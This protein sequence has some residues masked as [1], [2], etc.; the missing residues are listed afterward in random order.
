M[1]RRVFLTGLGGVV[2]GTS[3]LL[4][5]SAATPPLRIRKSVAELP[6]DHPDLAAL[7]KAIPLMRRSGAW[8][9]Q[10]AIHA[11]IGQRHHSSWRFLPWHRI[12]LVWFE[13][14][15]ARLSGYK[16]FAL[17]YWDWDGD[18]IPDVLL[19]DPIL[20]VPGREAG[21]EDRISA[22]MRSNGQ[23][24]TGR[25]TDDFSTFFGRARNQ[26]GA[27]GQYYSGSG[28]WSG[29]NLIHGFVG[30]DMGR[31]D[32][33]PNDPLFW[34][35]HANIDRVWTVWRER[36][37]QEIY[38]KPWRDEVLGGFVDAY[39]RSAPSTTAAATLNTASFGYGYAVD[40]TPLILFAV[41]PRKRLKDQPASWLMQ[42]TGPQSGFID[43]P[44]EL[45]AAQKASAVGYL[46][47]AP[48]P[49][50]PS[51]IRLTAQGVS[52][53]APFYQ[54]AVVLVPMVG[55]TSSQGHR[56]N[57]NGLWSGGVNETVRLSVEVAPLAGRGGGTTT[58]RLLSLVLDA[59]L[60]FFE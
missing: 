29:H 48:D 5:A 40:P 30:G 8:D 41:A 9:T 54:D 4:G 51:V 52:Q 6:V 21:P 7:R 37:P 33:S 12:Q 14:Q 58:T 46:D 20:S 42:Q 59:D 27:G 57:M 10:I 19:E 18:R 34:M 43:I 47:V 56:L 17:P 36:N 11:D 38:P 53:S 25:V 39:G 3:S 49:D 31:L 23:S 13:R 50:G 16:D 32:R 2:A 24:Y 15:V 22:F 55:C 1:E 45:A 60:T 26:N 35:H 44:A 28:E